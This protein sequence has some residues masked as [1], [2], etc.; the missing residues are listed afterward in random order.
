MLEQFL[1]SLMP[2]ACFSQVEAVV[3]RLSILLQYS[4]D[5]SEPIQLRLF[6]IAIFAVVPE[7]MKG[8]YTKSLSLLHETI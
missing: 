4:S 5:I 7:P 2:G 3:I 8:S 6:M 1:S